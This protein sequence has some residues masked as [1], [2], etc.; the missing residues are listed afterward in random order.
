[1][2]DKDIKVAVNE[3]DIIPTGTFGMIYGSDVFLN[4]VMSI[5]V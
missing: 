1:M 4:S 3:V 2:R 5:K